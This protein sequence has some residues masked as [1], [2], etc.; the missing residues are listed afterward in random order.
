MDFGK[1]L[2]ILEAR[3]CILD[4]K[5][6][7]FQAIYRLFLLNQRN[8]IK[9]R[10]VFIRSL[11]RASYVGGASPNFLRVEPVGCGRVIHT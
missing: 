9:N 11:C 6:E 10:A 4:V 7:K 3:L 8:F 5:F 2:C 1:R